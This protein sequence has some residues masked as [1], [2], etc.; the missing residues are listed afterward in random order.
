MMKIDVYSHLLPKR[1]KEALFNTAKDGF[2]IQSTVESTP[3]TI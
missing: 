1:Y 3:T 2:Y